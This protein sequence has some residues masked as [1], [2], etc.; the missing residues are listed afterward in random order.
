ME[1]LDINSLNLFNLFSKYNVCFASVVS[2]K[3]SNISPNI[4][5]EYNDFN[6]PKFSF[7][8]LFNG[9]SNN[10]YLTKVNRLLSPQELNFSLLISILACLIISNGVLYFICVST[11]VLFK[12]ELR[13]DFNEM[14]NI[15]D[16]EN[17]YL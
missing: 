11:S 8:I 7:V 1:S 13:W 16:T 15:L 5:N 9:I 6:F 2:G 14:G 17:I 12:Y 3:L 10:I 4:F